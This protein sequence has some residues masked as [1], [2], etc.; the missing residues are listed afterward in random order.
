MS[1]WQW[2]R[3][4]VW[5]VGL[6]A[7]ETG[8]EWCWELW[9]GGK[10][11]GRGPCPLRGWEAKLRPFSL[12]STLLSHPPPPARAFL[13]RGQLICEKFREQN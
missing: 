4:W 8:G 10:L 12:L 11:G 9:E 2:A 5:L 13:W 1:L 7:I 3:M 6:G